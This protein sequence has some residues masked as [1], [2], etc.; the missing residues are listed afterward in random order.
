[1]EVKR[2]E[3]SSRKPAPDLRA[4]QDGPNATPSMAGVR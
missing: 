1:M 4:Q 2:I 3:V